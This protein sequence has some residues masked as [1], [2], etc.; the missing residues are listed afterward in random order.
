MPSQNEIRQ[1]ITNQIIEALEKGD[2]P[3]W[4]RPW[5]ISKNSGFP[6]NIKSGNQYRGINPLLLELHARKH[7]FNSKWWGTYA[8][9]KYLDGRVQRR[10]KDVDAGEWGCRVVFWKQVTK[11]VI[12]QNTGQEEEDSFPLMKQY[13]LFNA[14]QVEG[15]TRY[16][17]GEPEILNEE[18][19]NFEPAE[20]L[21][22]A[23]GA[24][25]RH[26]GDRAFYALPRPNGSWP[27]HSDGDF[28]EVPLKTQ[29]S[30][31]RYYE[32]LFHEL[33]HWSEVRVGEKIDERDYAFGELVAEI[34]SC[35][36]ATELQ[37]PQGEGLENHAAY[38]KN[39]LKAMKDD[40]KFIF[41]AS[42]QASKV[43]DFLLSFVREPVE[44]KTV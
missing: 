5:S 42:T 23:T 7:G 14:D 6:S 38:L 13:T 11:T 21:I 39:W 10:P 31:S 37:I 17:S 26:G 33:A 4:R 28:I 9:W 2:L 32:T 36:L 30:S 40:P 25:I 27:E 1:Q 20:E 3:P 12:N 43:T 19:C 24:D 15:V 44:I 8:Q 16:Q 22:S 29:F 18:E 34:A 35:Y 41:A